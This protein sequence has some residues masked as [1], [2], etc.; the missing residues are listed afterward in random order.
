[1]F[2]DNDF[3]LNTETARILYHEAAEHCPIIDYHCHIN[4]RE[5]Y[6]DRRYENITQV[7]L[8]ATT[9]SGA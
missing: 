6:E 5:I 8:G 3:L 1:M 9:T 7:W 2:L 4:P